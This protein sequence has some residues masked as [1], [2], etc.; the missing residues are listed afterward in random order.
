MAEG[1]TLRSGTPDEIRNDPAVIATYLGADG[2][3]VNRSEETR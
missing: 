2:V 1:I 3:A